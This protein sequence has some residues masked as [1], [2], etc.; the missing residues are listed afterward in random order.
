MNDA[1]KVFS[2]WVRENVPN[3][4]RLSWADRVHLWF[5]FVDRNYKGQQWT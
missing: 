3:Y 5:H 2:R 1:V 4:G